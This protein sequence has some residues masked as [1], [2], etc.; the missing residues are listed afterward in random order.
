VTNLLRALDE[1]RIS[2]ALAVRA[3]PL[4][5]QV[6]GLRRGSVSFGNVTTSGQASAYPYLFAG[7]ELDSSGLYHTQTRYYSPTF[8][9]FL[10]ADAGLPANAFTYADDDPVNAIDP[11]GRSAEYVSGAR[12]MS[13]AVSSDVPFQATNSSSTGGTVLAQEDPGG[14]GCGGA[15]DRRGQRLRARRTPR[16][17][18]RRARRPDRR[19]GDLAALRT[20]R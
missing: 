15:A 20:S 18:P 12:D 13:P 17:Q 10:S 5:G 3:S 16:H 1:K 8:G 11:S 14:G 7:M 6:E 4:L 19:K 2:P 9:R